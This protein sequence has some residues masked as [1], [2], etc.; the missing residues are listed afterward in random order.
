MKGKNKRA[1]KLGWSE[2]LKFAALLMSIICMILTAAGCGNKGEDK[3]AQNY[4]YSAKS[5]SIPGNCEITGGRG[6]FDVFDETLYFVAGAYDDSM[7]IHNTLFSYDYETGEVKELF[8]MS[9]DAGN[10]SDS[11]LAIA[12]ND[13]ETITSVLTR[14]VINDDY[15]TDGSELL[16][17]T[18]SENGEVLDNIT[19]DAMQKLDSEWYESNMICGACISENGHTYILVSDY[20]GSKNCLWDISEEGKLLSKTNIMYSVGEMFQD[21]EGSP[22]IS[23]YDEDFS[24]KVCQVNTDKES[25]GKPIEGIP[26][27]LVQVFGGGDAGDF[28]MFD[29]TLSIY[30][31]ETNELQPVGN[32]VNSGILSESV[33]YVSGIDES[34][35]ICV[36]DESMYSEDGGVYIGVFERK[37]G[38][39]DERPVLRVAQ[40]NCRTALGTAIIKHNR[41]SSDYRIESI[42]YDE[43]EKEIMAGNVPDMYIGEYCQGNFPA[44]LEKGFFEDLTPYMDKDDEFKQEMMLDGVLEAIRIDGKLPFLTESFQLASFVGRKSDMEKLCKDFT[45]DN[46]MDYC[47]QSDTSIMGEETTR[48]DLGYILIENAMADYIDSKT[49][50]CTFDSDEIGRM[51]EFCKKYG[52]ASDALVYEYEE[53]DESAGAIMEGKQLFKQDA[54]MELGQLAA[55]REIMG[56]EVLYMGCPGKTGGLVE[57]VPHTT[58]SIFA[59]AKQKE[60]A[61]DFIKELLMGEFEK[62]TYFPAVKNEFESYYF[63]ASNDSGGR[64]EYEVTEKDRETLLKLIK[65][66]RYLGESSRE[67]FELIQS[68]L[69]EYYDGGKNLQDAVNVIEDKVE[70]YINENM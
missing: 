6:N 51:M 50:T 55:Y 17:I 70:K 13:N 29:E 26:E 8:A 41:T 40:E 23:Y 12:V 7:C 3:A 53:S 28:I 11:I 14:S 39:T 63:E 45:Y 27:N 25:V 2:R 52:D 36:T 32:L 9:D 65:Q 18:Y 57:F 47:E 24:M 43:M 56:E 60:F 31:T 64:Y 4:V 67:A 15:T 38:E 10:S 34:R 58:L 54:I 16:Q 69:D 5:V 61:W 48:R 33:K 20:T 35:L 59:S 68:D 37:E 30:D 22:Y 1:L 46:F 42:T 62:E 49:G 21:S 44:Y 66:S 19:I